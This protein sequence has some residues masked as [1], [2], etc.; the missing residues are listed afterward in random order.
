[1]ART[2]RPTPERQSEIDRLSVD[3][4]KKLALRED[5]RKNLV[6]DILAL[7]GDQRQALVEGSRAV[8]PTS[9]SALIGVIN[10]QPLFGSFLSSGEIKELARREDI[11]KALVSVTPFLQPAQQQA[12]VEGI[13]KADP[14]SLSAFTP[15]VLNNTVISTRLSADDMKKLVRREASRQA[16]VARAHYLLRPEQRIILVD[17]LRELDPMA[18]SAFTQ[19]AIHSY[20]VEHLSVLEIKQLA[21][22]EDMRRALLHNAG[23]LSDE[24]Q[25]ALVNGMRAADPISLSAFDVDTIKRCEPLLMKYLSVDDIKTLALRDDARKALLSGLLCM[26]EDQKRVLDGHW[27]KSTGIEH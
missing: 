21:V 20:L 6:S 1:M 25:Q 8:D 19:D 26:T 2:I 14:T 22:Q 27:V 12:L 15:D 11:R 9:L 5:T 13:R 10:Q 23:H 4:V 3:D 24:Q 18:L 17:C 16:L 7:T